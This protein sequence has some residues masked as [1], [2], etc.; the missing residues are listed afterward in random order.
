M[1]KRRRGTM[2]DFLPSQPKEPKTDKPKQKRVRRFCITTYIDPEAVE[3]FVRRSPWI[4]HFALCT[5]NRDY[6]ADGKQKQ[7]HTHV[8]LYT[9]NAHSS[10]GIRKNFD[11]FSAEYYSKLKLE[12]QNTLVQDCHSVVS[13][14]RYL[15]HLDDPD[16]TPYE[17]SEVITDNAQYWKELCKT[18]GMNDGAVNTGLQMF[19][20]ICDGVSTRE[21]I[22]RYGKEYIYHARLFKECYVDH[23]NEEKLGCDESLLSRLEYREYASALLQDSI[24]D[25]KTKNA[26]FNV[27]DYLDEQMKLSYSL[28]THGHL[29]PKIATMYGITEK[30]VYDKQGLRKESKNG[31]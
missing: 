18:N 24:F 8:I 9:F 3:R 22:L 21:M 10:S 29:D 23:I 28:S 12:P 6:E 11:V 1:P 17:E 7:L 4:Q 16:K 5:H 27:L 31:K 30:I 25:E 13:Q 14:F 19:D 15:R 20:D 26:F 2:A